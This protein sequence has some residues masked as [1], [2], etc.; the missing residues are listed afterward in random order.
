MDILRRI[1]K[2]LRPYRFQLMLAILALVLGTATQVMIPAQV[3]VIVDDG[4]IAQDRQA[5]I[6]AALFMIGLAAIGMIAT[7]MLTRSM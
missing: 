5:I 1:V 3:Q 2:Q 6:Q 4:I 7:E